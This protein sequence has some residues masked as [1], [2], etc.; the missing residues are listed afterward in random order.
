MLQYC[1]LS[2]WLSRIVLAH[3]LS[4]YCLPC[5]LV[6]CLFPAK[7]S[8]NSFGIFWTVI[9]T[10][11]EPIN[12]SFLQICLLLPHSLCCLSDFVSCRL[13]GYG[14]CFRPSVAVMFIAFSST[15]F[16]WC[17]I[18]TKC[19]WF[20]FKWF[21]CC[22]FPNVWSH[23]TAWLVWVQIITLIAITVTIILI[24][25]WCRHPLLMVNIS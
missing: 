4:N 23:Q 20:I 18:L 22:S 9:F 11:I 25:S 19:D 6:Y 14:T 5:L 10:T 12:V 24:L 2:S 1:V 7:T 3:Y 16:S 8:S 15:S 13:D 17:C 21:C